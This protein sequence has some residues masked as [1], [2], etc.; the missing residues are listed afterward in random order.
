MR[1]YDIQDAKMELS[2]LVGN[3]LRGE[4]AI[5]SQGGQTLVRLVPIEPFAQPLQ[6]GQWKG[7]VSMAKDFDELPDNI[8]KALGC[9]HTQ[10]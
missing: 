2:K 4:E 9:V 6:V 1:V 3:A 5:I 8:A 7:Q 10:D